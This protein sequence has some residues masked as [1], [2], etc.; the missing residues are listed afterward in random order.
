MAPD[1]NLGPAAYSNL[2]RSLRNP[3]VSFTGFCLYGGKR[4]RYINLYKHGVGNGLRR[5]QDEIRTIHVDCIFAVDYVGRWIFILPRCW[6][7]DSPS[8]AVRRHF[9]RGALIHGKSDDGL[10]FLSIRWSL[11]T[12]GGW[13]IGVF[14]VV[15]S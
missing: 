14:H 9:F 2:F 7:T 3:V 11:L 12:G 8:V 10:D 5:Q 4:N 6:R 1:Y 15:T 13:Q